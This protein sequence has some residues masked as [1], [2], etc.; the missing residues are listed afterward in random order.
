MF[1]TKACIQYCLNTRLPQYTT[2]TQKKTLYIQKKKKKKLT[3]TVGKWLILS[4]PSPA[5]FSPGHRKEKENAGGLVWTGHNTM[6]WSDALS[7]Y[8][9]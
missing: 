4:S 7:S 3:G 2:G 1:K 5:S 9:C 6:I 8:T